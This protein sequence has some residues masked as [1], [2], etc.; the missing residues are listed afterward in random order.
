MAKVKA[1]YD[2]GMDLLREGVATAAAE[3]KQALTELSRLAN[4]A[5]YF[6]KGSALSDASLE[7]DAAA[8]TF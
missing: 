4:G 1:D 2:R 8:R 7:N 6:A 3:E 5:R